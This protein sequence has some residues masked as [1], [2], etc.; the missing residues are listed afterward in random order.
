ML[1]PIDWEAFHKVFSSYLRLERSVV[2][3]SD[4]HLDLLL[5]IGRDLREM[6]RLTVML[7]NGIEQDF[8]RFTEEMARDTLQDIWPC[9]RMSRIICR[10]LRRSPLLQSLAQDV[11]AFEEEVL[12]LNDVICDMMHCHGGVSKN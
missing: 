8:Y 10:D 7:A 6:T 4:E 5:S 12:G 2:P 9:V 1:T 11:D 3:G